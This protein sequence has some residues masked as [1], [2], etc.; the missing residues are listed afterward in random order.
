[1]HAVKREFRGG[2]DS[3]TRD[4]GDLYRYLSH[5]SHATVMHLLLINAYYNRV[6]DKMVALLQEWFTDGLRRL[7]AMG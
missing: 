6:T 2:R 3:V 7:S 4:R 5:G 1:M